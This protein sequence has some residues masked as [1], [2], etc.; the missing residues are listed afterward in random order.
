MK[1]TIYI[2]IAISMVALIVS[3]I[4]LYMSNIRPGRLYLTAGEYNFISYELEGP[5]E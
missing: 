2:P 3:I 4:S 1:M 5:A